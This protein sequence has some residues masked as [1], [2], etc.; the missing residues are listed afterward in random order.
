MSQA[1]FT[2][3]KLYENNVFAGHSNHNYSITYYQFNSS[4]NSMLCISSKV[5]NTIISKLKLHT[6]NS[7]LSTPGGLLISSTLEGELIRGVLDKFLENTQ[8]LN[9]CCLKL[10]KIFMLFLHH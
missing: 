5:P 2:S 1:I 9:I 6:I 3:K 8:K 10:E 4:C 7:Q